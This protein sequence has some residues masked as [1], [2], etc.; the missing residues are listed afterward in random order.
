MPCCAGNSGGKCLHRTTTFNTVLYSQ[1]WPMIGSDLLR[2]AGH[3]PKI[4][5][6]QRTDLQSQR[7]MGVR[8]IVGRERFRPIVNDRTTVVIYRG[9]GCSHKAS[10]R[11]EICRPP[12]TLAG[13]END[14]SA[15]KSLRSTKRTTK[16]QAFLPDLKGLA[17]DR[18]WDRNIPVK[19]SN[20][21]KIR[22]LRIRILLSSRG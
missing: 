20:F 16:S 22:I 11:H 21:R 13:R 5:R 19:N 2:L 14:E 8:E 18:R 7:R 12:S 4:T 3:N 9:I 17:L 15:P 1:R 10:C 6:V